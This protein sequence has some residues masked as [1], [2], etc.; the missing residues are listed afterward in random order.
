MTAMGWL[1]MIRDKG[2]HAISLTG[3]AVTQISDISEQ[4][5]VNTAL[6]ELTHRVQIECSCGGTGQQGRGEQ[7]A[8]RWTCQH[9]QITCNGQTGN[10]PLV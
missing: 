10:K 5:A 1:A 7:H 4:S 9:V 2:A 6:L 8:S 3:T